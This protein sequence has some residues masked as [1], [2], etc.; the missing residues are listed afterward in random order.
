LDQVTA[1]KNV[2]LLDENERPVHLAHRLSIVQPAYLT[3]A[4]RITRLA[5]ESRRASLQKSTP[6][7][8]S[9]QFLNSLVV[10]EDSGFRGAAAMKSSI[11]THF[12]R[13]TSDCLGR[14]GLAH[15]VWEERPGGQSHVSTSSKLHRSSQ[16]SVNLICDRWL[17]KS[18]LETNP[19]VQLPVVA[20]LTFHDL[21]FA[22][23]GVFRQSG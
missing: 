18:A 14:G 23:R 12:F 22:V 3:I 1:I 17:D 5:N 10:G 15:I 20:S 4:F 7:A 6:R 16:E 8:I 9:V 21:D 2:R 13:F 19:A 11:E